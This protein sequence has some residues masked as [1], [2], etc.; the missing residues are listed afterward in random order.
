MGIDR[1][2]TRVLT[3]HTFFGPITARNLVH[4][5]ELLRPI[6]MDAVRAGNPLARPLL[7]QPSGKQKDL[8]PY[9]SYLTFADLDDLAK[10]LSPPARERVG[11]LS[12]LL[13]R[14]EGIMPSVAVER[15]G[16]IDQVGEPVVE[17]LAFERLRDALLPLVQILDGSGAAAKAL[18]SL[19][20]PALPGSD[21][22]TR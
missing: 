14:L 16:S 22:T 9:I 20:L 3:I 15:I 6:A 5:Q 12:Q 18:E 21:R 1:T 7:V 11:A 13:E 10:D 19:P 8:E 2:S 17:Y 4:A